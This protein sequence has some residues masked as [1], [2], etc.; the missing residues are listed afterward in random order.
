[1]EEAYC[2]GEERCV[3]YVRGREINTSY[4]DVPTTLLGT[5]WLYIILI[6]EISVLTDTKLRHKFGKLRGF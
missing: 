2:R 5:D 6:L 4:Y 3:E 1:M